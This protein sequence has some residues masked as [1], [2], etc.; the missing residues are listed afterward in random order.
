MPVVMLC[1]QQD[2]SFCVFE[3]RV[4]RRDKEEGKGER[5]GREGGGR[6]GRKERRMEGQRWRQKRR[7]LLYLQEDRHTNFVSNM[8]HKSRIVNFLLRQGSLNETGH[9]QRARGGLAQAAF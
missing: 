8:S 7:V 2:F 6:E 3:L 1:I 9:N 5:E 4:E